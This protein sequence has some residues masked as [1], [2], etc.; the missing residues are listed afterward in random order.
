[1]SQVAQQAG[2]YP[3]FSACYEATKNISTSW[4]ASPSQAY[5]QH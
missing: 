1:M 4:D 2:A 3:D 5:P